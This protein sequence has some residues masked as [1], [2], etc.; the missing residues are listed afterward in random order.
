M[1]CYMTEAECFLFTVLEAPEKT[2]LWKL[3]SAAIRSKGDI[4]LNVASSGSPNLLLV[5]L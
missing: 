2:F 3:L 5:F 4:S 1:L